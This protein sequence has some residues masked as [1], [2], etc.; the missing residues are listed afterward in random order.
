M[1]LL[2]LKNVPLCQGLNVKTLPVRRDNGVI[3]RAIL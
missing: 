2:V 3:T 1:F